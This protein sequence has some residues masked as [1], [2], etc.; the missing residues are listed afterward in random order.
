MDREIR[1]F[2]DVVVTAFCEA[3]GSVPKSTKQN[4]SQEAAMV[5]S[6]IRS[7]LTKL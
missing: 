2:F 6:G 4:G 5:L 3:A 7:K 1:F